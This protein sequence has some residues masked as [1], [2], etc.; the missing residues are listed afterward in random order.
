MSII[1]KIKRLNPFITKRIVEY[2]GKFIPQY[3]CYPFGWKAKSLI[4]DYIWY[5]IDFQFE[6][7]S[8]GT[9]EEARNH[10]TLEIIKVHKV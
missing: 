2:K 10:F 6:Y 4:S 1:S 8:Y 5:N 7:C 3:K 9:L